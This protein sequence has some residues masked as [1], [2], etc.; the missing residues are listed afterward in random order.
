MKPIPEGYISTER[1][2]DNVVEVAGSSMLKQ[3]PVDGACQF[4]IE[5]TE[6]QI[7]INDKFLTQT[8]TDA[9]GN[10]YP[11]TRVMELGFPY[12]LTGSLKITRPA[13]FTGAVKFNYEITRP[14]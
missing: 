5:V 14:Q 13:G 1:L 6:G 7:L 4:M 10:V 11:G 12:L 8:V 2:G 3:I 9:S